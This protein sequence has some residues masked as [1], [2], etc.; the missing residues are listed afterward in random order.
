MNQRNK[1]QRGNTILESALVLT[2]FLFM[3]IG[4]LDFGQFL[5]IHQALVERARNAIR[6]G[7]V[8]PYDHDKIQNM[9]LY[10]QPTAPTDGSTAIFGLSAS[11]VA[12]SMDTTVTPNQIQ[13]FINGYQYQMFSPLIAGMHYGPNILAS[14]PTEI[15]N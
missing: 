4:V 12:V 5:Y 15:V 1:S 14:S 11:N 2:T 8:Q 9:V 7:T 13:V 3:M 6:W 10:N